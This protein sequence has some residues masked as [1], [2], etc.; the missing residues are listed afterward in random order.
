MMQAEVKH[1]KSALLTAKENLRAAEANLAFA[2]SSAA[3]KRVAIAKD[4]IAWLNTKKIRATPGEYLAVTKGV[5]NPDGDMVGVQQCNACAL[6]AVFAC[7]VDRVKTIDLTAALDGWSGTYDDN[8]MRS[9]LKPYFTTEQL[10]MIENAFERRIVEPLNGDEPNYGDGP[11][12][13]VGN[14]RSIKALNFNKGVRSPK[15]R[16]TRIMKNII[17]NG[18]EFR[19]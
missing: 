14:P 11:E 4:V 9:M 3:N 8:S 17:R 19:P 15:E 16:L 7:A 10:V 1:A 13:L 2:R 18:G 6:G 12:Y 5:E